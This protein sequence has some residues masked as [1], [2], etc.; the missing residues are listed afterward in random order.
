MA[1]FLVAFL[2]WLFATGNFSAWAALVSKAN[3]RA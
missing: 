3:E 1:A 2:V